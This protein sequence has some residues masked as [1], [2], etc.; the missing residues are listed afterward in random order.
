MST[1][2]RLSQQLRVVRALALKDL[3]DQIHRPAVRAGAILIV[4]LC[5]LAAVLRT[6]DWRDATADYR[7]A[8]RRYVSAIREQMFRNENIEIESIRQVSPLAVLSTGLEPLLPATFISTKEGLRFGPPR[9]T[10]NSFEAS[11]GYLDLAA[12]VIILMPFFAFAMTFDLVGAAGNRGAMSL[13]LSYPVSPADVLVAKLVACN[14]VV[15]VLLAAGEGVAALVM[16]M[17]G[18]PT[19]R[20]ASWLVFYLAALCYVTTF[21]I[22]GLLV[23]MRSTNTASAAL[24]CLAVWAVAVQILPR[25]ASS[26]VAIRWSAAHYAGMTR[27]EDAAVS[28][29]RLQY[30]R[31]EQAEYEAYLKMRGAAGQGDFAASREATRAEFELRRRELRRRYWQQEDGFERQRD[32]EAGVLDLLSP[33]SAM[34]SVASELS[35]TG[36]LQRE[37]FV[38]DARSFDADVARRFAESRT[39]LYAA[40]DGAV[41]PVETVQPLP[42]AQL[43]TTSW[44]SQSIWLRGCAPRGLSLFVM[45][46]ILLIVLLR[47]AAV[48]SS[49]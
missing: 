44:V 42:S 23:S 4:A 7:E 36:T 17:L 10:S 15:A 33:A 30:Q 26:I 12:V 27:S 5:A 9:A 19:L 16:R 18:A 38:S 14:T 24:L 45:N 22:V 31:I 39:L 3:S 13:L 35:W 37:Q 32:R 34:L 1:A 29:L 21:V 40:K 11:Y 46:A 47:R 28:A 20:P 43:F 2:E 41:M 6:S 48:L 49:V 25:V 8:R